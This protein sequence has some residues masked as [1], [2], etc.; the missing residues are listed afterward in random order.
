[1][2]SF[3]QAIEARQT[4]ISRLRRRIEQLQG[5]IRTLQA[6]A[7]LAGEQLVPED[8]PEPNYDAGVHTGVPLL[9]KQ[10]LV[11]RRQRQRAG[12]RSPVSIVEGTAQLLQ[13]QDC[14]DDGLH[15]D[16]L[17]VML[18]ALLARRCG[19]QTISAELAREAKRPDAR[20]ERVPGRPAT[21]RLHLR[22]EDTE[23]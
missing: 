4:E 7:K 13:R 6:A 3:Q 2:K 9:A 14:G 8:L 21:F 23:G 22:E 11:H 16:D 12:R 18:P 5:E 19:K 10:R 20:I 15:V 1:M 17:E